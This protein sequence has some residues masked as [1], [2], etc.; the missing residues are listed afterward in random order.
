MKFLFKF[1]TIFWLSCTSMFIIHTCIYLMKL[2][3]SF[4]CAECKNRPKTRH[5]QTLWI[6]LREVNEINIQS[7]LILYIFTSSCEPRGSTLGQHSI[8]V[9]C[10]ITQECVSSEIFKKK[11]TCYTS[12]YFDRAEFITRTT[13]LEN[14]VTQSGVAGILWENKGDCLYA[15]LQ[16]EAW[17]VSVFFTPTHGK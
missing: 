1:K 4:F 12:P 11:K 16:N 3:M 13:G 9:H 17:N 8:K 5:N 15:D 7:Y 10:N 2:N 6:I 14:K